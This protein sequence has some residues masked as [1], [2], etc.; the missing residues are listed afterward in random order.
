MKSLDKKNRCEIG[1]EGKIRLARKLGRT[2]TKYWGSDSFSKKSDVL[3]GNC[4]MLVNFV[5]E[6]ASTHTLLACSGAGSFHI[7]MDLGSLRPC[8]DLLINT[9]SWGLTDLPSS[10]RL[11][12]A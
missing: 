9:S 6:E 2:E 5:W 10:E 1:I 8:D 11:R 4:D 12:N 3:S 7:L